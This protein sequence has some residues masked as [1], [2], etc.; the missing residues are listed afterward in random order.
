MFLGLAALNLAAVACSSTPLKKAG[1]AATTT[2]DLALAADGGA[3]V[4]GP[5]LPGPDLAKSDLPTPDTW[6][7][8][9]DA[10]SVADLPTG[11]DTL[12]PGDLA[13][14]KD[15]PPSDLPSGNDTTDL[16]VTVADAPA[17][18]IP[19][20]DVPPSDGILRD[21]AT[22]G[23]WGC[24]PDAG[25]FPGCN[26]DPISA[27]IM[28]TCQ[29]DNTC[30]C[31]SPYTI[32]PST[33]RCRYPLRDASIL[34]STSTAAAC[35][36]EYNACGCGCCGGVQPTVQC[37][38]P[39]LGETIAAITVQDQATKNATNCELVGCSMGIRHVCC[40]EPALESPAG[41]N[42]AASGYSGGLEHVTISKSGSECA[43]LHFAKPIT[44]SSSALKITMPSSWGVAG[45][46]AGTCGGASATDQAK[47]GVG[48]FV[49]RASGGD[50]VADLHVTLFAFTTDGTVK[51]SR[52]D[53]DG[54][55]V[56]GMP[57]GMCP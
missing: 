13:A 50:C 27:A 31:K 37:Y 2:P 40:A 25:A 45:S 10:I 19:V 52:M 24:N 11:K 51:A 39:S 54:L 5:D 15:L 49:L 9:K 57:G 46:A 33:G 30:A 43:T 26:D 34:D 47:G 38:Y 35:T 4:A 18:E 16:P 32:N 21:G 23:P 17:S 55:V 6:L 12:S 20:G 8:G 14:G 42:Y 53:V 29:P 1:D 56:T 3:D 22:D 7:P 28:G 41:V 36:G 48:T 44:A